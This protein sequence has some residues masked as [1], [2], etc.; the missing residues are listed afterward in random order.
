MADENNK[1]VIIESGSAG[2][3]K[4]PNG[5]MML[6]LDK[7]ADVPVHV[8]VYTIDNPQGM[9][10]YESTPRTHGVVYNNGKTPFST[11]TTDPLTVGIVRGVGEQMMKDGIISPEDKQC[12]KDM[13]DELGKNSG[14]LKSVPKSCPSNDRPR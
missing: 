2:F 1:P 3:I 10:L 13:A 6:T 12:V 14:K 8:S 11:T 9:A 5:V 7:K 4:K